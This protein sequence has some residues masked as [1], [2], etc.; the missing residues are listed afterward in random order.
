MAEHGVPRSVRALGIVTVVVMLC[1]S[2]WLFRAAPFR[3]IPALIS[4]DQAGKVESA[5]EAA[6]APGQFVSFAESV[7]TEF[8]THNDVGPTSEMPGDH[9][10]DLPNIVEP[11]TLKGV[12]LDGALYRLGQS[13]NCR[14]VVVVFLGTECPISNALIPQLNQLAAE[15]R[16]RDV[17]FFGTIS[18]RSVSRREALQHSEEYAIDFPVLLD[19]TGELR[20]RLGATHSPHAFVLTPRGETVYS[21]AIDDQFPS[22]GRKKLQTDSYYLRDAVAAVLTGRPVEPARTEAIG[23]RLE[24]LKQPAE[25]AD[26]TFAHEIAPIIFANCTTCHREGAV[27]PFPLESIVDVRRH[28]EQIRVM[29]ELKL[30]PPWKPTRGFGRFRDELFLTEREIELVGRWIDAGMPLGNPAEVP[31]PPQFVDG[32]QLGEPDLVLTVPESFRIPASGPDIYQ[33][34]V[35]P[36]GLTEDRL[37]AA[38][39]YKAGNSRVVH[40]ASF[41]YDDAGDARLL[42][43]AW[44]GPGY[45]RFGGWGFPSGGTLGGWAVGV[46]PQ[47]MPVDFGRPIRAGSDFVIQTHYHPTGKDEIDQASVGIHFAP[48]TAKR[49]IAELFVANMELA[50]PPGER[51][52][53][54]HAEYTL[55]IA[56][57]LHS[58]LPHTHLLGRELRASA[59]LPNGHIEPLIEITDWDFN[60]QGYYFYAQPLTLPAGTKIEFDVVFDNSTCNPL[61]PHSP[62]RW[63]RWGEESDAE[64]AVCFFDVSTGTEAELDALVRHNLIWIDSQS[65]S[66]RR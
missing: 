7:P 49:R 2:L 54:H 45:Q 15:C 1:V 21:G 43:A 59:T 55:P 40:H 62:P 33:Y 61:N 22:V 10:S 38:I 37:V 66:G 14:A 58:V 17:E 9:D 24:S 31:S 34:F 19:T 23:C 36:T 42:D 50:I 53:R 46:L 20:E 4:S 16:Q 51:R 8:E 13:E 25:N 35:L 41:R 30:M 65:W 48:P 18:W 26:V 52:F 56:V 6:R 11:S 44:P 64:M 3:A 60:W 5:S 63:V 28:A 39:E 27:A 12:G 47:R 32:W 57:A 29:V